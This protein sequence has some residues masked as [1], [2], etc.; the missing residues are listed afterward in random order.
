MPTYAFS[1]RKCKKE[2][3]LVIG[4]SEREKT[5]VQ[6]PECRSD[7][8]ARVIQWFSAKTSKKS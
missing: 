1:C 8:V 4:L 6:C 2:F 3:T 5:K 7:D